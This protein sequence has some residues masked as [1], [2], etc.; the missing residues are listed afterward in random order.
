M[1][2]VPAAGLAGHKPC[3]IYIPF[4]CKLVIALTELLGR[5]TKDSHPYSRLIW[6][7]LGA[8]CE[9]STGPGI[10]LVLSQPEGTAPS[11]EPTRVTP[12][13]LQEQK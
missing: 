7:Y 9:V 5:K 8:V 4:V 3:F 2:A 11:L 12:R 6:G 10:T 13:G 1:T